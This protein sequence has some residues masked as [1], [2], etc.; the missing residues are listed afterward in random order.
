SGVTDCYQPVEKE[1]ELTRRCLMVAAEYRNPVVIISKNYLLTRDID[2]LRE[3]QRFNAIKVC[4]SITTL[5]KDLARKMEPRA[6]SPERRLD[7]VRKLY[8]ANIPVGV[9]MAPIIPG[10]ADHEISRLLK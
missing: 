10:L 8:E 3:L 1:L 4:I 7:A 2:I 9:N 6:S 5:D